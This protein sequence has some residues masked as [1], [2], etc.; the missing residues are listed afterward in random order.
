MAH[1]LALKGDAVMVGGKRIPLSMVALGVGVLG[2]LVV[3]RARGQGGA[4]LAAGASPVTD[5]P[6]GQYG[7]GSLL[8]AMRD[9]LAAQRDALSLQTGVAQTPTSA[10]PLPGAQT[11]VTPAP[12]PAPA[13]AIPQWV[14]AAGT[15]LTPDQIR[16][17]QALGYTPA[18]LANFLPRVGGTTGSTVLQATPASSPP[19]KPLFGSFLPPSTPPL[20]GGGAIPRFVHAWPRRLPAEYQPAYPSAPYNNVEAYRSVPT[21]GYGRPVAT[22]VDRFGQTYPLSRGWDLNRRLG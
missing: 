21:Q 15:P 12:V 18:I 3:M 17:A 7:G 9:M 2:V 20:W 6:L 11:P 10:A 16:K 14:D 22:Y 4:V 19:L 5:A 13:G 1:M 8:G